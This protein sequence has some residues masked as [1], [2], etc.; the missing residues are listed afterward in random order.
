VYL[1]WAA[2]GKVDRTARWAAIGAKEDDAVIGDVSIL[3]KVVPKPYIPVG[4]LTL[5]EQEVRCRFGGVTRNYLRETALVIDL[6][7]TRERL[8]GPTA[9]DVDGRLWLHTQDMILE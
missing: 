4:V 1:W 8:I 3:D 9:D 5:V 7:R 6:C 2:N